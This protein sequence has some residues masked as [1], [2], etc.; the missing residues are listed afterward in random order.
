MTSVATLGERALRRLGV[1]IV[2]VAD[3]P[4]VTATVS[5]ATIATAAL[6]ELA[7]IAADETPS[8]L[9]QALAA[10]KV[11]AVHASLVA[12]GLV[13]WASTAIP[14][15]VSEEYTKLVAVHLATSFGKQANPEALALME[16]RIRKVALVL[17]APALATEA[18]MG[19]HQDL[20]AL[21]RVRWSVWDIPGYIEGPYVSLAAAS[22]APQ[23]ALKFDPNEAVAAMMDIMRYISLPTSGQTL[24]VDYF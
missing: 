13:S 24:A 1:A 5:V 11:E 17:S 19:V 2:A 7:I 6:V 12:Q 10:A 14:Q 20:A 4:A 8:T 22:L 18:V 9:D 23:F 3:R 16:G 21:G 15:S